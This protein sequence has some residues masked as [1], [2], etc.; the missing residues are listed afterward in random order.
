[1]DSPKTYGN[2]GNSMKWR[3]SKNDIAR[4]FNEF[5]RTHRGALDREHF[6]RVYQ[7]KRPIRGG[8][9]NVFPT[10]EGAYVESEKHLTV[11][12]IICGKFSF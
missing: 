3:K 8:A 10:E 6:N 7:W 1:M 2:A 4:R 5:L 12:R 9:P 11:C